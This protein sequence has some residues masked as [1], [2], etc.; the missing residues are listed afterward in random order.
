[1]PKPRPLSEFTTLTFDCYGTLIDW[2]SG[3][4]EA[5]QPL[6]QRNGDADLSR[7]LALEL[8][9]ASESLRESATPGLAYPDILAQV[10][11]DL[12]E[13]LQLETDPD[14]DRNFGESVPFWPAFPDSSDALRELGVR[15]RLV[16]LSNV[17]RSSFAA[18]EDRLQAS[19][20][21]VYTAEDIGFY[22]PD[23]RTFRYM[24]DHLASDFGGRPE[25]VLHVAQSLYHDHVPAQSV[26]LATAW[27]DRQRLSEGGDWGATARL[28][29]LPVTDYRF[30]SMAELAETVRSASSP[31]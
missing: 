29:R 12:A 18:S 27:I 22:K 11:R 6:L 17:D 3:I 25:E 15:Y 10:H 23:P 7:S 2:E 16:I 14:M 24:L 30:F 13:H 9:A 1:M 31:T 26:G 4:W 5:L 19:F 8:F 28:E 20:D 21:A